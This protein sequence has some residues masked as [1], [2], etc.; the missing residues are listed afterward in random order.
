MLLAAA[1]AVTGAQCPP[2]KPTKQL[3]LDSLTDIVSQTTLSTFVDCSTES[4]ENQ[5]VKVVQ[6]PVTYAVLLFLISEPQ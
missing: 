1:A 6:N 4:K 5:V 3:V 2:A